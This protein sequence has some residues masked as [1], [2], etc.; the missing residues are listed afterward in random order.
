MK[1]W[2]NKGQ[3]GKALADFDEIE[4]LQD[5]MRGTVMVMNDEYEQAEVALT[6]RNT[7]FHKLGLGCVC[8]LKAIMGMQKDD[9]EKACKILADAETTASEFHKRAQADRTTAHQSAIY[10]PG[11]EYALAH[12]ESQLMYAV[13]A[14]LNASFIE[15][16]KGLYKIKKAWGT[17]QEIVEAEKKYLKSMGHTPASLKAASIRPS[18]QAS[19]AVAPA[20]VISAQQPQVANINEKVDEDE[21]DDD[22]QDAEEDL[23]T[24]PV[25]QSYQGNVHAPSI[26]K[27]SLNGH[28]QAPVHRAAS[29]TSGVDDEIDFRNITTNPVDLFI[30]AGVGLSFG[31]MQLI[32]SL[33]PPPFDSILSMFSFNGDRKIGLDMLWGSTRFIEDINGALASLIT[34]VF[35][36]G[37]IAFSNIIFQSAL[38]KDRLQA[39]LHNLRTLYPRSQIWQIEEA[40]MLSE[41]RQLKPALNTLTSMALSPLPSIQALGMFELGLHHLYAHQYPQCAEAFMKL[42]KLSDWSHGLYYYIAAIAYVDHYRVVLAT[43][44]AMAKQHEVQAIE[45]F[46]QVLPN[47]GKKKVLGRELPIEIFVKRKMHKYQARAKERKISIVEAVGVSP[48]EDIIYFWGGY[49]CM[50]DT[51]LR[52]SIERLSWSE[53]QS[54]W[55][56]EGADE[57]TV[58]SVLRATCLRVMGQLDQAKTELE[59]GCFTYTPQQVK[60]SGRDADQ[61]AIATAHYEMAV[62]Y[63][64]EAGG[65]TGDKAILQQCANEIHKIAKWGSYELESTH[66]LKVA[67][68]TDTLKKLGVQV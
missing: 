53:N 65:E 66:G 22:F 1:R 28:S 17:L 54:G 31:T 38:P 25:S 4:A 43:D 34:L 37:P 15:S 13:C 24:A 45:Y 10:P 40:I 30:H 21:D 56:G 44:P 18:S 55:A 2:L 9:I 52:V 14:V 60:A 6:A 33:V 23:S 49:D 36:N 46:N 59:M 8:F 42:L 47:L 26:E 48:A 61:W 16:V 12:A 3:S 39:L 50:P 29:V 62:C 7:P 51:D 32:L 20:S 11:T 27:L 5:A 58:L 68:A 19:S 41:D 35:H 63:W 57:K 64:R 67:T